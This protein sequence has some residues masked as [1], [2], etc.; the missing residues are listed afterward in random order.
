MRW[1]AI[2][3]G[4]ARIGLAVSDPSGM[5]ASPA[6]F[7]ARR[8]GKKIPVATLIAKQ[9]ELGQMI[10]TLETLARNCHGDERP[11]CPI[12]EGLAHADGCETANR[13]LPRFGIGSVPGGGTPSGRSKH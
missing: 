2:D 6:G 5:I 3:L 13:K 4:D 1:L 12:I 9:V 7:V 10:G 8:R 11:E